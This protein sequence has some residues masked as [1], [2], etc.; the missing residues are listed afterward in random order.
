MIVRLKNADRLARLHQQSLIILKLPQRGD[1]GVVSLPTAR[2]A[3]G[4][5][6]HDKILRTLGYVG[7]KVVHEHAHGSFLLPTF[8]NDGVAAGRANGSRDLKCTFSR[9]E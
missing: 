3:S 4:S 6:V 9:T 1:D 5:A 7:I 8:A 2:G